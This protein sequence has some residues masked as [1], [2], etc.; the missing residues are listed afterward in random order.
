M[1]DSSEAVCDADG[2]EEHTKSQD[3]RHEA[4]ITGPFDVVLS[5]D[6]KRGSETCRGD[7]DLSKSSDGQT[8]SPLAQN[9][10]EQ[11]TARAEATVQRRSMAA[12]WIAGIHLK[13]ATP[14][15]LTSQCAHLNSL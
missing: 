6:S 5:A 12:T 4:E 15:P 2:K 10:S 8:C 11:A 3:L 13:P 14:P 9:I 7:T 1:A